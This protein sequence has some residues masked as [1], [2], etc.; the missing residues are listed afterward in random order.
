[1]R[2][3]HLNDIHAWREARKSFRMR[4][5]T[6]K[7][8]TASDVEPLTFDAFHAECPV[9][10]DLFGDPKDLRALSTPSVQVRRRVFLLSLRI[11][12]QKHTNTADAPL[13]S[14]I[15]LS[16]KTPIVC[17]RSKPW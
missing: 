3:G 12:C 13:S 7:Y 11:S 14:S 1:V 17:E 6:P 16:L 5:Y 2:G 15:S 4:Y 8:T 9:G 10:I